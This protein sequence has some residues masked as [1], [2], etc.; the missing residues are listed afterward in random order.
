MTVT[1][2]MTARL[3]LGFGLGLGLS[4]RWDDSHGYNKY[5]RCGVVVGSECIFR[6]KEGK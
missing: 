1:R 4:L 3:G 5:W 2:G 6:R